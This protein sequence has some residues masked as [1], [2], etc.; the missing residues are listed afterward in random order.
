[1]PD[2]QGNPF[3]PVHCGP[4]FKGMADA[5][6]FPN[7][8]PQFAIP[9]T[10]TVYLENVLCRS[11]FLDA[12]PGWQQ[13]SLGDIP[14]EM[15]GY[16]TGFGVNAIVVKV[17]S[18]DGRI[19]CTVS[20]GFGVDGQTTDLTAL[21]GE[22]RPA[23]T[24]YSFAVL[25]HT[26]YFAGGQQVFKVNPATLAVEQLICVDGTEKQTVAYI[27]GII[28]ASYLCVHN[29]AL[30]YVLAGTTDFECTVELDPNDPLITDPNKIQHGMVRYGPQQILFSDPYAPDNVQYI[31]AFDIQDD[32]ADVLALMSWQSNLL[33]FTRTGLWVLQGDSS[34]NWA[35]QCQSKGAG[36]VS[37]MSVACVG[38]AVLWVGPTNVWM[39][40]KDGLAQIPGTSWM[41]GTG[42]AAAGALLEIAGI[43]DSGA[44]KWQPTSNCCGAAFLGAYYFASYKADAFAPMML[45]AVEVATQQVSLVVVPQAYLGYSYGGVLIE[46]RNSGILGRPSLF[47]CGLGQWYAMIAGTGPNGAQSIA[48][49]RTMI[50]PTAVATVA[51]VYERFSSPPLMGAAN[52]IALDDAYRIGSKWPPTKADELGQIQMPLPPGV[53]DEAGAFDGSQWDG[54]PTASPLP[55]R[56]APNGPTVLTQPGVAEG[57]DFLTVIRFTGGL[58]TTLERVAIVLGNQQPVS[59]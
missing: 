40:T 46:D 13:V 5:P 35:M 22:S 45:L 55:A 24:V 20:R 3:T 27:N 44:P 26:I 25:A 47:V 39:L 48:V 32:G 11:G 42:A 17:G 56:W 1:M 6:D 38:D 36:C 31:S 54:D 16:V 23:G 37:G 53:T 15:G 21:Y 52:V 50:Q 18:L 8:Y 12:S 9:I 19:V 4:P 51:R 57:T 30:W 29:G 41:F 49:L 28:P 14:S 34:S 33:I 2:Q 7:A 10:Q 58:P 43:D 59:A